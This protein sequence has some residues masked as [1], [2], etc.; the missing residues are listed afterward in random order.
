MSAKDTMEN[1]ITDKCSSCCSAAMYEFGDSYMCADCK[2]WCDAE[3]EESL[4]EIELDEEDED[5]RC[6]RVHA[7]R[8]RA[9]DKDEEGQANLHQRQP[10]F[11]RR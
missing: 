4:F 10:E 2:E 11:R 8:P 6:H 9:P 7:H 1:K 5:D 3:E